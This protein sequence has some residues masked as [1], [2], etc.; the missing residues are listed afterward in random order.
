MSDLTETSVLGR[1]MADRLPPDCLCRLPVG[2]EADARLRRGCLLRVLIVMGRH[3]DQE[4]VA[5]PGVA[6]I[7]GAA[8][9][10]QRSVQ[11]ALRRLV[12]LGCLTVIK[13]SSGGR[14][15]TTEYRLSAGMSATKPRRD[16]VTLSRPHTLTPL[17]RGSDGERVTDQ[18]PQR[19]TAQR[20]RVTNSQGIPGVKM[21]P[22]PENPENPEEEPTGANAPRASCRRDAAH[23]AI[24]LPPEVETELEPYLRGAPYPDKVRHTVGDVLSSSTQITPA[25]VTIA[26]RQMQAKGRPFGP[27]TLERWCANLVRDAAGIPSASDRAKPQSGNR[28][29]PRSDQPVPLRDALSSFLAPRGAR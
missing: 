25:V 27:R 18:P 29:R 23:A 3:S 13:G 19:V 17:R 20:E 8:G 10:S 6:R 2:A 5:W 14:H 9:V 15:R 28:P 22:E 12:E 1:R 16:S 7:A 26:L 11:R 21:S 24:T 4:G